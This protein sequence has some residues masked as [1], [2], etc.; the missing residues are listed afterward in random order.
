MYFMPLNSAY[1]TGPNTSEWTSSNGSL[2]LNLD[3]WYRTN[4]PHIQRLLKSPR[5]EALSTWIL[6]HNLKL[7]AHMR[8]SG[9]PQIGNSSSEPYLHISANIKQIDSSFLDL[10]AFLWASYCNIPSHLLDQTPQNSQ[11]LLI[12]KLIK[13]FSSFLGH[14]T[15][16]PGV[17]DVG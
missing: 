12:E 5:V 7:V 2:A 3:S 8:K 6:H 11:Q 10:S 17:F 1:F 4:S 14:G 13:D 9:L 16:Y 15:R